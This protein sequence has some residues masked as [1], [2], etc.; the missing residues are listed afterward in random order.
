MA[1]ASVNALRL[2]GVAA[3]ESGQTTSA[4]RGHTLVHYRALAAIVEPTDVLACRASTTRKWRQYLRVLEEAYDALGGAARAAGTIFQSQA[5][6][7][8]WLELHYFTLTEALSVIEGHAAA[9]VSISHSATGQRRRRGA[10]ELRRARSRE[11]ADAEESGGGDG[12]AAQSRRDEEDG[13]V[14]RASFLVDSQRWQSFQGH[15]VEGG[16]APIGARLP[17]HRS[18]AAVRLRAHAVRG[19]TNVLS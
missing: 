3:V 2:Y 10:Q 17:G 15:G 14:A 12:D 8:R 9:R 4:G 16:A 5:T 19:L 11:S 18:V 1:Q 13:V 6:L 7:T